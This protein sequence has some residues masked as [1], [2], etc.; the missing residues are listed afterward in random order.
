MDQAVS[1]SAAETISVLRDYSIPNGLLVMPHVPS[2][3]KAGLAS[4]EAGWPLRVIALIP[5]TNNG[6]LQLYYLFTQVSSHS[7]NIAT[8]FSS[9][10]K[11]R[12]VHR[13]ISPAV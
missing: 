2:S 1:R 3:T 13:L 7:F 11:H 9:G 5:S 4:L 6:D 12:R 10:Y 8:R